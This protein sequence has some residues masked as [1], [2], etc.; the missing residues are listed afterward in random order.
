MRKFVYTRLRHAP[1]DLLG[2]ASFMA[3]L[4]AATNPQEFG[5]FLEE[6]W[7]R[8]DV[9]ATGY[10]V[11]SVIAFYMAVL[12]VTRDWN[13]T[14][15]DVYRR[16]LGVALDEI[17]SA[18]V[19]LIQAGTDDEFAAA[20]VQADALRGRIKDWMIPMMGQ[21]AWAKFDARF[22][23]SMSYTWI[24]EHNQEVVRTRDLYLD[25][26]QDYASN[27]EELMK[28]D[29]WDPEDSLWFRQWRQK[30]QSWKEKH[31]S[32]SPSP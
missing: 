31:L 11:A 28:S 10:L 3:S 16:R 5:D 13:K 23:P 29:A 2:S 4:W 25:A 1:R 32:N 19:G 21:R 24:G 30:V 14:D 15:R 12:W 8:I 17:R 27:L 18:R 26:F 7:H 22:S 20:K 9:S 6:R